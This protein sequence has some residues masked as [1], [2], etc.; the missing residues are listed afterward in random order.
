MKHILVDTD[1]GVDDIIAICLLLTNPN[2]NIKAI[3]IVQG[4]ADLDRGTKNLARILTF[5]GKTSIPIF[6][7]FI[8]PQ[9]KI[10]FPE[11]DRRRANNLTL[12]NNLPLPKTSSPKI[13]IKKLTGDLTADTLLCLG[14]L[15]N[16]A[17]IIKKSCFKKIIIMGGAIFTP[18]NIPP[19]Y[20]KEYNIAL[21]PLAA[22]LVFR[23]K[24]PITL[25]ATDT[26]KQASARNK[27]F[28]QKI[29][30][31]KPQTPLG[32]IIQA[33]ILN[34]SEDFND[35]YD[36][37]AAIILMNSKIIIGSRKIDLTITSS[38]QTSGK[39][40]PASRIKLITNINRQEFYQI[41]INSIY[42]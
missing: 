41:L 19:D 10:N 15:T 17:K 16:V 26:T 5:I 9:P 30:A 12:L 35:F 32:K 28:L 4:V 40:S 42:Y 33:I 22:K 34:N 18:G 1:M 2:I 11:I 38:G 24:L 29:Q 14:P 27:F 23:S 20:T 36:P 37:L 13:A 25:I 21:D 3:S 6:P 8:P 39:Y 31:E 7:G